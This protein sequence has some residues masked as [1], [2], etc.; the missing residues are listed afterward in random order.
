VIH[1]VPIHKR[2]GMSTKMTDVDWEIALQAFRASLPRRGEKRV[3]VIAAMPLAAL[4]MAP[5]YSNMR[6]SITSTDK[7][8]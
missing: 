3:I 7:L 4:A 8:L 5:G 2:I 6:R 1:K